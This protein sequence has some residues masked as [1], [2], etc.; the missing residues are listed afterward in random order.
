MAERGATMDLLDRRLA[1]KH[2]ERLKDGTR[3]PMAVSDGDQ[4]IF[5]KYSGTE[6]RIDGEDLLLVREEEIFAVVE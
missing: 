4:V 1:P 2:V 3:R 6:V 5:G